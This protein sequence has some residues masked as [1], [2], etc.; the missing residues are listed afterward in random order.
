MRRSLLVSILIFDFIFLAV[1]FVLWPSSGG[2][3]NHEKGYL[4]T[5]A[6][7][8]DSHLPRSKAINE[9]AVAWLA[10]QENI[11]FVVHTGDIVDQH[12]EKTA[13]EDA[14]NLMHT[15]DNTSSWAVL[16]GNHDVAD[17]IFDLTN[18][19]QYFGNNSID[20]Y[21]IIEDKL[22]FILLSWNNTDGS[23]TNQR[24]EWMDG[25]IES[26]EEKQ[27]VICLQPHLFGLSVLNILG[28]PNYA[29]IWNHIS[30]H[31]N[32]VIVLSGHIHM[33]WVRTYNIGEGDVWAI[34]TE[35][36]TDKGYIRLFDVY[37]DKIEVYAYSP[38]TNQTYL[39]PLDRFT[40]KLASVGYDA[41]GDLWGNSLD[42]MPTHPLIPNGLLTSL[43]IAIIVTV[44]FYKEKTPASKHI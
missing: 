8:T 16:A 13:W 42:L 26:Y 27:A 21:F 33:N 25:I 38:W 37:K 22:L 10:A 14:Y 1:A 2:S 11:S 36:V 19:M 28:A 43:G 9:K 29:E 3:I 7:I 12:S 23:I 31:K 6:Q 4:F 34:S 44:H 17:G 32:V 35:A 5:F 20:Q 30:K 40:I 15:L 24:L 41:D 39:G 18:Y